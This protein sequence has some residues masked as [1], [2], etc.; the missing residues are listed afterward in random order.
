VV[1]VEAEAVVA[2]V[3]VAVIVPDLPIVEVSAAVH[4]GRGPLSSTTQANLRESIRA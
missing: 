3:A 4:Q 2:V 1:P